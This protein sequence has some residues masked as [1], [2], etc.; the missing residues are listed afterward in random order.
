MKFMENNSQKQATGDLQRTKTQKGC[1]KDIFALHF[2]WLHG[3][4]RR[5]GLHSV[6]SAVGMVAVGLQGRIGLL[7][8]FDE[9]FT[10]RNSN[11]QTFCY[12]LSCSIK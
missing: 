4:S 3:S 12:S 1:V 11:K 8:I 6:I 2:H 10:G 7:L 5:K 9:V